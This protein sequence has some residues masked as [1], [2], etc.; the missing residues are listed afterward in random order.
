MNAWD[1]NGPKH[2]P[3]YDAENTH[4][5]DD[6]NVA[7]FVEDETH[8]LYDLLWGGI[9][10]ALI[11]AGGIALAAALTITIWKAISHG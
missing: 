2:R 1:G 8:S 10:A 3:V 4:Q 5:P 9:K 6:T 7:A 11:L